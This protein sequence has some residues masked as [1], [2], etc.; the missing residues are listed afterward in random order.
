MRLRQRDLKTVYVRPFIKIKDDEGSI[1]N[2]YGEAYS[3]EAKI[4]PAGGQLQAAEYGEKLSY[5]LTMRY[6][7]NEI[8]KEKDGV[9]VFVGPTENPDYRVKAIKPWNIKVFDLEKVT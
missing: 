9:C 7:G 6:E 2:N 8:L 1:T 3:I 5:M 4:Q